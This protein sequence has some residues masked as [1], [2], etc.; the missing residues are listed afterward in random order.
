MDLKR[1]V[2]GSIWISKWRRGGLAKNERQTIKLSTR[3]HNL[4]LEIGVSIR[5]NVD[6]TKRVEFL[7]LPQ[8]SA[9]KEGT[10]EQLYVNI[11]KRTNVHRKKRVGRCR[12]AFRI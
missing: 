2:R 1:E 7:A 9:P 6:E 8:T 5:P 4:Q 12:E 11:S 3:A 10:F